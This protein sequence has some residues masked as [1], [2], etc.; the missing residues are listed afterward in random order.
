MRYLSARRV[1]NTTASG[2]SAL[3][4]KIGTSSIFATSLQY[5]VERASAG[6]E[7]VKPTWL[8]M[9]TCTVPPVKK[10]RAWLKLQRLHHHALAGKRSIPVQQ[11]R[12]HA[13]GALVAAPLL[14]GAYRAL[15]H[16]IDDLEVRGVEGQ[17]GMHVAVRGAQVRR[18]T[19]VVLDVARALDAAQVVGALELGEQLRGGLAE[20]I[21][22]Y[23]E[24][25]AMRHADDHL[26]HADVPGE[27]DQVIEQRDERI[28]A[29]ER[30]ALLSD[31]TR[32]QV[33]LEPL[34]GASAARGCCA[35]PRH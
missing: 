1:T 27:L 14:P 33:A 15:D 21:H 30:E 32:V 11:K 4:W 2:S 35:A 16:R 22:Q 7:V 6:A 18:E 10:P 23:V 26:L 17:H 34:G 25:P 29:L 12:Q 20:Q 19:L 24:A 9:M 3:T 13:L 8:L 31:V 28:L 5:M